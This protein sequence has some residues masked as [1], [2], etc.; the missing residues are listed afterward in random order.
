MGG[1]QFTRKKYKK[2]DTGQSFII[3][4]YL[5]LHMLFVYKKMNFYWWIESPKLN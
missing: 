5:L 4:A 3:L 2:S 1:S